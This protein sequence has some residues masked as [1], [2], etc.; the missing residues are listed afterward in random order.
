MIRRT[1]GTAAMKRVRGRYLP[2]TAPDH[3]HAHEKSVIA[4]PVFARMRNLFYGVAFVIGNPS[5]LIYPIV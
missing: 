4:P 3:C 1:I 2:G 5:Y